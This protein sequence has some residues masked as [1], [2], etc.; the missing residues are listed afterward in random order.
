MNALFTDGF[1]GYFDQHKQREKISTTPFARAPQ[2]DNAEY[3]QLIGNTNEIKGYSELQQ[4][5]EKELKIFFNQWMLELEEG[6]SLLLFGVGSKMDIVSQFLDEWQPDAP[7]I[8]VN[9]FNPAS[10]FKDLLNLVVN[11][12]V[13]KDVAE[14]WMKLPSERLI[15]LLQHLKENPSPVVIIINSLDGIALRNIKTQSFL[16]RLAESPSVSMLATV[17]HIN[18]PLLW[19]QEMLNRFNF[20]WHHTT[21]YKPYTTETSYTDILGLGQSRASVGVHAVK[22]VL[23]SLTAN[24]QSL[25]KLLVTLQYE[26]M[27]NNGISD[28]NT[29]GIVTHG[30]ELSQFYTL[31]VSKFVVSNEVNFKVMFT[32]FKEHKMVEVVRKD[33]HEI[34]FVPYS[35]D[36]LEQ[37]LA[38]FKE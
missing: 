25:Y 22:T 29:M 21:T 15:L 24:A 31:C 9:G 5:R 30:V 35:F 4:Y 34:T 26:N 13:D 28:P 37:L 11:T 16:S 2:L 32:E 36:D 20:V 1:E 8:I 23:E 18:A 6:F 27:V 33:G 3:V 38:N 14:G 12:V 7:C 19:P 17:D 10:N